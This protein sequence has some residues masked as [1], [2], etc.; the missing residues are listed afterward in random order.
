M[1]VEAARARDEFKRKEHALRARLQAREAAMAEAAADARRYR[2][3]YAE[4]QAELKATWAYAQQL[5]ASQ[6]APAEAADR[7][8]RT[9]QASGSGS[10]DAAGALAA[11]VAR[12]KANNA[13]LAAD[14]QA[15][16][17]QC[18]RERAGHASTLA[19]QAAQHVRVASLE[20]SLAEATAQAADARRLLE[21]E[22]VASGRL[23]QARTATG[24]SR[25]LSRT[26]S[27]TI[28]HPAISSSRCGR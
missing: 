5:L 24:V 16:G 26:Q 25:L 19:A 11:E 10:P 14:A 13:E 21:T 28:A 3:K 9:A 18:E 23:K 12:L 2:H 6:V 4:A 7:P 15:R 27:L 22:R 8:E 17:A 1:A 20:A